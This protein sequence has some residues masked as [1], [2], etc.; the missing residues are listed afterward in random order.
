[1]SSGESGWNSKTWLRL[2]RALIDRE[3]R[4]AGRRADQRDDPFLDVGQAAR[5]AGPC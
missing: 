4:I 1:M 5:P 2:T 3:E